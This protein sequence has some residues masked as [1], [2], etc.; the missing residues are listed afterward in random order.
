MI[1]VPVLYHRYLFVPYWSYLVVIGLTS[2]LFTF[3]TK[4]KVNKYIYMLITPLLFV[5]FFLLEYPI[6]IGI[7]FSP[8]LVWRYLNIRKQEVVKRESLYILLTVIATIYVSIFVHDSVVMIYPFLQFVLLSFGYIASHLVHVRKN[9]LKAIDRKIPFYFVGLLV[10]SAGLFFLAYP[11]L[12]QITSSLWKGIINFTGN[13]ILGVSNFLSFFQ[14]EKRGWPE[15][16]PE[17]AKHGDG[18]WDELQEYNLMEEISGLVV[19]GVILVLLVVLILLI[20]S[21]VKKQVKKRMTLVEINHSKPQSPISTYREDAVVE[22]TKKS[23][24]KRNQHIPNNPIRKMVYQFER[25]AVKY[26][27]GRKPSE[28]VEDWFQRVGIKAN[29]NI[30]QSVRYGN[31]EVSDQEQQ[32][33]KRELK[34]MEDV[35]FGK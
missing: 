13:S 10:A 34:H 9:D 33:L 7:L 25:K 16:T 23:L 26:K 28:T 1:F 12:R 15:Q 3:C 22:S 29:L 14:V 24:F 2:L 4:F 30:Y 5:V 19:L 32:Q 27:K 21:V 20:I 11:V 17:E 8:L 31:Q 6:L 35:L 18:Y